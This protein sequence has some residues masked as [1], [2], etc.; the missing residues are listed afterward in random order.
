MKQS[1][2][3]S[4]GRNLRSL[5][6]T[7]IEL[8]VV[9]AIIAILAA[10]LLPA[11]SKAKAAAVK[12]QCASNLKQWG[13]AI[14]MYAGDNRDFFPDNTLGMDL[15]WMSPSLM[16]NFY[17]AYLNP[18]R[19]G[20][21]ASKLR[22]LNDVLY[23]PTDE[24]HRIAETTIY[25]RDPHLIGYFS[26][27]GRANSALNTWPY[28]SVP[29]MAPWHFRKKLGGNLRFA[30]IM[31]DRVQASGTWNVASD[32]GSVSWKID[33]EGHSYFTASHRNPGGVPMGGNFLF[34]DGHVEWRRF[35][36]C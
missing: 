22:S 23:C 28:N 3:A 26:L 34:E 27:P 2:R 29:G 31:S 35:D 7:L 30:P 4:A 18:N 14:N 11:L 15:S 16:T 33:F 24:W 32:K 6:F 36:I 20:T 12:A 13:V 5:A 19:R 10:M 21:S 8:L 17:P 25:D 9:I 1:N